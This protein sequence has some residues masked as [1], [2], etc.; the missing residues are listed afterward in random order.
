VSKQNL[1]RP[2][3][4]LGSFA[5]ALRDNTPANTP[6]GQRL[7]H[8]F[9]LYP[10]VFRTFRRSNK[11]L[12][13]WHLYK[14]G[15]P[16]RNDQ[17]KAEPYRLAGWRD[18]GVTARMVEALC[19]VLDV[20]VYI[21]HNDTKIHQFEPES[22]RRTTETGG[23][24]RHREQAIVFNIFGDHA[25]F[26]EPGGS[27]A[28]HASKLK[29]Y[30]RAP[31]PKVR[32]QTR[33]DDVIRVPYSSMRPFDANE[34]ILYYLWLHA[35]RS[36]YQERAMIDLM[37]RH[38]L[39][40]TRT[41]SEIAWDLRQWSGVWYAVDINRAYEQLLA[42]GSQVYR[43]LGSK[44]NRLVELRGRK[45]R[46]NATAKVKLIDQ[47]HRELQQISDSVAGWAKLKDFRYGDSPQLLAD[48]LVWP[49]WR[50]GGPA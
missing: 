24:N 49:P 45:W 13:V 41:A 18:L 32:L 19:K 22:L 43:Q 9:E 46:G 2:Y 38:G 44:P 47:F 16:S 42:N 34:F 3:S 36:K 14:D 33:M 23:R 10:E 12:A 11:V 27:V 1:T 5:D 48:R 35:K 31:A 40:I 21:I 50:R 30:Q 8:F 26:Y 17:I 15:A 25:Y 7:W 20:P 29:I 39:P 37:K 4:H 28:N 6:V